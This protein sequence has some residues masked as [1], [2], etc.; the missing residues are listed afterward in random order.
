VVALL[1]RGRAF[2]PTARVLVKTTMSAPVTSYIVNELGR[3]E[4]LAMPLQFQMKTRTYSVV[5]EGMPS[6]KPSLHKVVVLC[7]SYITQINSSKVLKLMSNLPAAPP[8]GSTIA[9]IYY[10]RGDNISCICTECWG[11]GGIDI[12]FLNN[13]HL[14]H[15]VLNPNALPTICLDSAPPILHPITIKLPHNWDLPKHNSIS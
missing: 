13:L 8:M 6:G 10:V 4:A 3:N 5:T 15:H 14:L 9:H 11:R 7:T 2:F 12:K 1:R